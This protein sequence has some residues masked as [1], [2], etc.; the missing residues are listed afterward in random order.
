MMTCTFSRSTSSWVLVLAPAGLPPVSAMISS[1]LRPAMVLFRSLRNSWMPCSI[2]LPPA[3]SGPV[4]TVRKPM[5]IG[6][7]C[8]AESV[9]K[10][11][12][13]H[14][15]NIRNMGLLLWARKG[16]TLR[17]D[18][19]EN[20]RESI[21]IGGTAH[22]GGGVRGTEILRRQRAADVGWHRAH[23]DDEGG[24]AAT[25]AARQLAPPRPGPHR[26]RAKRRAAHRRDGDAALARALAR[27][28]AMAGHRSYAAHALQRARAKC[29]HRRRRACPRRPAY[30]SAARA[31]RARR[32]RNHCE[33]R[34]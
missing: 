33:R 17:I 13:T 3:A 2:C 28:E 1:T 7:V 19:E 29:R 16:S 24:R 25:Q 30:G 12:A 22:A 8:A 26:G 15:I 18:A 5:R 6:S 11:S 14:S 10:I 31:L 34:R 32:D 27:G 9:G 4:R 20:S 21:R 23:V